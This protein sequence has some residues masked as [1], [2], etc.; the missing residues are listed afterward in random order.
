MANKILSKGRSLAFHCS[1]C[2]APCDPDK[3][4]CEFCAENLSRRYEHVGDRMV[5]LKIDDQY[6]SSVWSIGAFNENH[7]IDASGIEDQ[8]RRYASGMRDISTSVP[9]EIP[10]TDLFVKQMDYG[11]AKNGAKHIAVEGFGPHQVVSIE[12]VA[13]ITGDHINTEVGEW[14]TCV[15]D[16]QVEE[17]I[18]INNIL[19]PQYSCP[20]CGAPIKSR[21]GCCDY[22]GGWVEWKAS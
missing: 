14:K 21:Y 13:I 9:I 12:F 19:I 15:L 8:T 6:I 7:T 17:Y 18:G 5:R 16:C 2:G 3:S 1:C 4:I 10:M 20:N 22:C 11:L